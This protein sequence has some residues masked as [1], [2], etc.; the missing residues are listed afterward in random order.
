MKVALAV[1]YN[2]RKIDLEDDDKLG[3]IEAAIRGTLNFCWRC[4]LHPQNVVYSFPADPSVIT[5]GVPVVCDLTLLPTKYLNYVDRASDVAEG[6][7]AA[8]KS[9]FEGE[10]GDIAVIVRDTR[11]GTV[12]FSPDE[13]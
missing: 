7:Q 2:L 10:R 3:K 8:L 9:L 1:I 12:A 11:T 13:P 4:T 6:I 5:T